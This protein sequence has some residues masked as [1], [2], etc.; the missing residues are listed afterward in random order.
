M[1]K[2]VLDALLTKGPAYFK[3]SPE[4]KQI[5]SQNHHFRCHLRDHL[6]KPHCP[7]AVPWIAV[8]KPPQPGTATAREQLHP[9]SDAA[10][11]CRPLAGEPLLPPK[12]N[13]C[14]LPVCV[15]TVLGVWLQGL[16]ELSSHD[17]S[18]LGKNFKAMALAF[19]LMMNGQH[20]SVF[21]YTNTIINSFN[22][23]LNLSEIS[24]FYN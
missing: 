22:N 12:E 3:F 13:C 24:C 17:H 21:C 18:L 19:L 5:K 10:S 16:M 23:C 4:T 14:W 9:L 7:S 11:F 6:E 20:G 1:N 15:A 8:Q 2:C